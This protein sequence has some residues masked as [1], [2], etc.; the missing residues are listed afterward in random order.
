MVRGVACCCGGGVYR[1][2]GRDS[3]RRHTYE[4]ETGVCL[5]NQWH[6]ALCNKLVDVV[7]LDAHYLGY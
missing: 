7:R 1:D 5:T 6:G 4:Q 3:L 2:A